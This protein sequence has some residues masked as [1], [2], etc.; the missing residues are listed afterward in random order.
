MLWPGAAFGTSERG[1]AVGE[2]VDVR[3]ARGRASRQA[4]AVEARV[5]QFA[6]VRRRYGVAA[7]PE[8]AERAALKAV[9]HFFTAAA[10]PREIVA[11]ARAPEDFELLLRRLAGERITR[12]IIE[13]DELR[14]A[15]RR[16]RKR[17]DEVGERLGVGEPTRELVGT[18]GRRFARHQRVAAEGLARKEDAARKTERGIERAIE[19]GLEARNVDAELAQQRSRHLAVLGL[20]RI[21]RFAAAVA[22]HEPAVVRELVALGVAAEIVVVV[23]DEDARRWSGG[24]TVEEGGSQPAD[25][26]A[27]DDEIVS[28]L[29]RQPLDGEALAF[30]RLRVRDLERAR[31]L[32]AQSDERRRIALGLGCNLR[33][34][35]EACGDGQGYSVEKVAARN[36]H[37]SVRTSHLECA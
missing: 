28:L 33:R 32:A 21:D 26:G 13:R 17:G 24:A 27:D 20:R 12:A 9:R 7:E 6:G 11:V 36:R 16:N 31:V 1:V 15:R 8:E 2:V 30:E 23:E 3:L 14:L 29:D 37:A 25:A 4:H 22:D 34:R 35:R 10:Y 5:T 18:S 19:R